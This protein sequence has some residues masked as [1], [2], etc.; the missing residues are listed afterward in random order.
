VEMNLQ[1]ELN[2]A[3]TAAAIKLLHPIH[4]ITVEMNLQQG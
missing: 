4:V 3:Q 2:F 1:Q